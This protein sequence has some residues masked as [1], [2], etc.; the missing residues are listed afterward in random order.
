MHTWCDEG[1]IVLS[2]IKENI[3]QKMAALG[4]PEKEIFREMM[5]A[6]NLDFIIFSDRKNADNG[7]TQEDLYKEAVRL[8][9]DSIGPVPGNE[10]TYAYIYTVGMSADPLLFAPE[11]PELSPVKKEILRHAI[12]AAGKGKSVLF[13]GADA[14]LAMMTEIFVALKGRHIAVSVADSAWHKRVQL[15]YGR[16]HVMKAEELAAD[17]DKYDYIFFAA[18]GEDAGTV[19]ASL[20][21]R[22]SPNGVL[23]VLASDEVLAKDEAA[24]AEAKAE[25]DECRISSFHHVVD[26]E[27]EAEL[28]L[29]GAAEPEGTLSIGEAALEGETLHFFKKLSMTRKNF[30]AAES[31]EYDLYAYNGNQALQTI[32]SA[33]L[34]DPDFSVGSVFKEIKALKGTLGTY[35][36]IEKDA[37]T[38]AG[39][40]LDLVQENVVGDVKRA[41]E[42]DL[43]LCDKEGRL[44]CAVVPKVLDGAAVGKGLFVFRPLDAYTA[45]YLKAYLDGPIGQL[46]LSTMR[47]G[48]DYC[49][50]GSR[51]L[52]VPLPQSGEAAIQ[53]ITIH[54]KLVTEKLMEAEEDWRKAKLDAINRMM[55]RE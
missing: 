18:E 51:V 54:V 55:K 39:I 29:C 37:V 17:T 3:V 13:A 50:A 53:E 30:A 48:K 23:E 24:K 41:A 21:L 43:V 19:W 31:W 4:V 9:T 16:G 5:R 8:T 10:D 7:L 15:I 2:S 47:A 45:E 32:L 44:S 27:E 36:I 20:R 40:R 1:R 33:G 22:L 26:G 34:V 49:L 46:F 14:Y 38:E 12:E 52:R 28:A 35:P 11:L 42:G 6:R 25:A